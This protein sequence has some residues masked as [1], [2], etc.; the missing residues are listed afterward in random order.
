MLVCIKCN[1]HLWSQRFRG[2]CHHL[3]VDFPYGMPLLNASTGPTRFR[4]K[5]T[6]RASDRL[7]RNFAHMQRA[8]IFVI[9]DPTYSLV[10]PPKK[11]GRLFDCAICINYGQCAQKVLCGERFINRPTRPSLKF[12]YIWRGVAPWNFKILCPPPGGACQSSDQRLQICQVWRTACLIMS[13][14]T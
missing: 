2:V 3:F 4:E 7:T 9:L 13:F 6:S 8:T 11:N 10:S 1:S 12:S 14:I 5:V